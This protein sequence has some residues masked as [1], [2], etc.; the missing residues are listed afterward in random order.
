MVLRSIVFA[1]CVAACVAACG[2]DGVWRR[3]AASIGDELRGRRDD[4]LVA[5]AAKRH[6]PV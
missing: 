5:R 4:E 6:T 2:D 3:E 1:A